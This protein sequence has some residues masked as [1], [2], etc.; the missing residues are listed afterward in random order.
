MQCAPAPHAHRRPSRYLG[1][2]TP[3]QLGG[4][5]FSQA[6]DIARVAQT[7]LAIVAELGAQPRDGITKL[8]ESSPANL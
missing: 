2:P 5:V 8:G 4:F 6:I 1:K 3:F 7:R